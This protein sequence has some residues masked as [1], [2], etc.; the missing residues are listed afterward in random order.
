M[1]ARSR[2]MPEGIVGALWPEHKVHG[3]RGGQ[4]SQ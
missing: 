3:S 4:L 2:D 1:F